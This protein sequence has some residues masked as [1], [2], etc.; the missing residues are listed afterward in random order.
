MTVYND[1]GLLSIVT[2]NR[3]VQNTKSTGYSTL[4]SASIDKTSVKT[5]STGKG[6]QSNSMFVYIRTCMVVCLLIL[7]MYIIMF[8]VY[9]Y[10]YNIRIKPLITY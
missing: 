7:F 9:L 1:N 10:T 8:N 5:S 6:V 4:S 2:G 3:T